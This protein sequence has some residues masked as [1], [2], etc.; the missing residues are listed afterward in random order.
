MFFPRAH[1]RL[2]VPPPFVCAHPVPLRV[3]RKTKKRREAWL[4]HANSIITTVW[5][6]SAEGAKIVCNPIWLSGSLT[7]TGGWLTVVSSFS[8]IIGGGFSGGGP[9]VWSFN[10]R[11]TEEFVGQ[12][13]QTRQSTRRKCIDPVSAKLILLSRWHNWVVKIW[14]IEL[15]RKK[16]NAH[17]RIATTLVYM[18]GHR[19]ISRLFHMSLFTVLTSQN[20]MRRRNWSVFHTCVWVRLC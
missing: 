7:R 3:V 14:I 15:K 12:T 4:S 11:E 5:R 13:S 19:W 6:E 16:I 17:N 1:T 18:S 2:P 20:R 9:N 10:H 8:F